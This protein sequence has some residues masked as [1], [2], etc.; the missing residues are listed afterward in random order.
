M[1]IIVISDVESQC[2]TR[3]YIPD[4]SLKGETTNIV[5]ANTFTVIRDADCGLDGCYYFYIWRSCGNLEFRV[6]TRHFKMK[7]SSRGAALDPKLAK[8]AP[9]P[10]GL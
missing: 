1:Y 5:Y 7:I 2:Q 4:P 6:K 9:P 10:F 3:R 8:G